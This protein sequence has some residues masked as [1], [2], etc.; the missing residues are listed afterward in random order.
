MTMSLEGRTALITGSAAGMGRSH[1]TLMAQR[2][3]DIIVHDI[4]AAGAEETADAVRAAGRR[5]AVI[6]VDVSDV[7]AM[8]EA[9]RGAETAVGPVDIVVN[10]AGVGGQG[11][12][13]EDIDEAT[14][15]RMFAVHVKGAFFA[16][17]CVVPGMKE[18]RYG[19]IVNISSNFAMGGV[20][21]ACHYA[22]AKSALSGFTKCWAR[23]LAP[24]N[25]MVNAVAPGLLETGL[26][27]GSIGPDRIRAMAAEVPLG[28]LAELV[29]IS[30][31]V[32]WLA[33]PETDMMTGQVISP[34]GGVT[35]IGI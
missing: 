34:N 13:F 6:V 16:T 10:N 32:A 3:A 12:A 8:G 24:F 23:E 4:D 20:G 11:L 7:V 1:A 33:S 5:A 15:D 25:I 19:K 22:A 2:G 29:E 21:F 35:I 17:Q 28:R 26:T 31:A 27:L 9:I 14:F 30:Y 18:R